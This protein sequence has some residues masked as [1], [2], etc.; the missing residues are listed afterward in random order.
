MKEER[1]P[2]GSSWLWRRCDRPR[3][4][5]KPIRTALRGLRRILGLRFLVGLLWCD[6]TTRV[7]WRNF[8]FT[9]WHARCSE[10]G[11]TFDIA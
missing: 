2:L 3:I 4:H 5:P 6:A 11:V 9:G 8:F 1:R 10:V 7:S